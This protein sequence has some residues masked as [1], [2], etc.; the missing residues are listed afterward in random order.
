MEEA[1]QANSNCLLLGSWVIKADSLLSMHLILLIYFELVSNVT[2][3]QMKK[4]HLKESNLSKV[5]QKW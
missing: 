4:L 5:D 2:I 3:L 1:N